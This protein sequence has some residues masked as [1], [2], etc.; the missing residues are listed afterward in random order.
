MP[1]ELVEELRKIPTFSDLRD[2][3][4]QWLADHAEIQTA[5]AGEVV[6]HEGDPADSMF[7]YLEGEID[8][9]RESLGPDSPV[10]SAGAGTVTGL[11]PFSRMTNYT[12][13]ARAVSRVRVARIR[14]ES[15]QEMLQRIPVLGQRLVG[16]L[17][18]RVR[19]ATRQDQARE[20]LA[21]LG[22]LSAGLAHELNNPAAAGS[23]AAAALADAFVRYAQANA[24]LDDANISPESRARL[25]EIEVLARE[26]QSHAP[27]RSSLEL[28]DCE[29]ELRTWLE[30]HGVENAWELAPTLAEANATTR[31]FEM[32]AE[33]FDSSAL[34][35]A[36]A[37][38]AVSLEIHR[39]LGDIQHSTCRISELVQ[40]IKEYSFMDEAPRQEVD[41]AKGLDST[42]IMLSHKLK[43]GVEVIKN[44]DP[45][46]PRIDS[47]GSELNQVW[48][49]LID[50][51]V[52]AMQGKGTLRV[53]TAR[54]GEEVLVEIIDD[55]SG[56]PKEIQTRIFDPF[57]TTKPMGQG[58]GLGLDTVYRIM[59][60]HRGN[61]S[62]VSRPGYTCFRVRLPIK[63][64]R[65]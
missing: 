50:N 51:A 49:N 36:I 19:E 58:T 53:R 64:T 35:A 6:L 65:L 8:G 56:I 28:S 27:V 24:R 30:A 62:F 46:L 39:L 61:V 18:D 59:R 34:G 45:D 23:R 20:K 54:E 48:T 13:T 37:R 4:L 10:Y 5:E 3:E 47:F 1:V 12:I 63:N 55:G 38:I 16:I 60:K 41:V 21:S 43:H 25:R 32:L 42:L 33:R 31:H 14:R 22:K 29:E 17:S 9:R 2:E 11:L 26:K 7:V 40:S 52:D 44:Y 15:F 57:F